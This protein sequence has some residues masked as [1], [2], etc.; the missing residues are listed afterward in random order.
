MP[1]LFQNISDYQSHLL[2]FHLTKGDALKPMRKKRVRPG[3][4]KNSEN[5]EEFKSSSS[6]G[7]KRV[8]AIRNDSGQ[9]CFAISV[10]HLLAQTEIPKHLE[11]I[12]HHSKCAEPSCL[13]AHFFDRYRKSQKRSLSILEIAQ[14]YK[15]FGI[16]DQPV[17]CGDFLRSCL[18]CLSKG[19]PE[20]GGNGQELRSLFSVALQWKFECDGCKR[21]M[22][23]S[24]EDQVLR[25]DG[26]RGGSFEE[27]L[28]NFLH[29]TK[30]RCGQKCR[31][32]P[33]VKSSGKYLFVEVNRSCDTGNDVKELILYSLQLKDYYSVFGFR[34]SMFG[35]INYNLELEG[36]GHYVTNLFPDEIDL[37]RI[38]EQNWKSVK[39]RPDFDCDTVIVALKKVGK[40][41][42]VLYSHQY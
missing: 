37:V 13:L 24:M 41:V 40:T 4:S 29:E 25:V 27:L 20:H 39:R 2:N 31:V 9:D 7:L 35:V 14:N 11:A 5:S 17:D 42:F 1:S 22:V 6:E 15:N 26:S 33:G 19:T 34:Y 36:G 3:C 38:H 8:V 28:N 32:Y 16:D 12:S 18:A 23:M 30:C 21:F 10:L